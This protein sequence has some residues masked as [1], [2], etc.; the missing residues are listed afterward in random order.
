[1][2]HYLQNYRLSFTA[3]VV[4]MFISGLLSNA[5]AATVMPHTAFYEMRLGE[6]NQQSVVQAVSGRSAFTLDQDCNGWR[7]NE[8]QVIEFSNKAGGLDRILSRFESWESNNGDMYSFDINELS[9]FQPEESFSG[10]AETGA[11][12]KNDH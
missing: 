11:N 6:A 8:D 1:M 7:S 4:T 5:N 9:S 2:I 12:K 10:Y 3:A